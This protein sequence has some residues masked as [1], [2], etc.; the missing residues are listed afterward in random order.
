M[1]DLLLTSC[2]LIIVLAAILLITR[3]NPVHALL[4][5]V[6]ILL[7]LAV[8]FYLVGAPFAAALQ[9]M[10]YAGAITV[11]FVFVVMML[12]LGESTE[13]QESQWLKA[14]NWLLPLL[15]S[16]LLWFQ[17]VAALQWSPASLQLVEAR[18][19][20]IRLF[21]TYLLLV[22]LASF[23]LLSALIG[24]FHIVRP[25]LL[26]TGSKFRRH[27]QPETTAKGGRHD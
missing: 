14:G 12:N 7:A 25:F 2:S 27:W 8:I 21:D 9:V 13:Q 10:I 18:D 16:A 20:G 23:L 22:E 24:A 3:R 1:K 19:V 4:N 6:L 11:L 26:D 17:L 15:C 5:L